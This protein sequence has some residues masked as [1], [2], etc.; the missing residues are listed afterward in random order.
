MGTRFWGV[1]VVWGTAPAMYM[2]EQLAAFNGSSNKIRLHAITTPLTTP[3]L[4][5]IDITV[6]SY[7]WPAGVYAKGSGVRISAGNSRFW[8]CV[9]RNGSLWCCHNV[10]NPT[11]KARW[12]E[13]AT[14]AWPAAGAPKLVQ[15]GTVDLGA[16]VHTFYNA[17]HVDAAQNALMVLLGSE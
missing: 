4:T 9:W 10:G 14:L 13:I 12:Y 2:V 11:V 8:S 7:R 16:G 3:K 1:P 15:Q 5:S 6:P 17:I